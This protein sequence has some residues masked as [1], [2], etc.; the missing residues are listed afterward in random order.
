MNDSV[1]AIVSAF[2][3]IGI[4]V[5][6]IAVIALSVIRRRRADGRGG[7]PHDPGGLPE[8]DLAPPEPGW[9]DSGDEGQPSWPGDSDTDFRGR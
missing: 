9:Q 5:G 2:F 6:V 8:Y 1:I 3:I 7:G 4:S